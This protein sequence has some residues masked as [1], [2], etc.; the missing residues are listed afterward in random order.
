MKAP[1]E[2][3][4]DRILRHAPWHPVGKVHQRKR[5]ARHWDGLP[6]RHVI[7][8]NDGAALIGGG[9]NCRRRAFGSNVCGKVLYTK[10]IFIGFLVKF[11]VARAHGKI[12]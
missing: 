10:E 1:C 9:I 3:I 4:F 2:R 12:G 8:M 7:D 6:Y 5:G 11:W